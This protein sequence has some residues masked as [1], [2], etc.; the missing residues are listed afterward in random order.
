MKKNL[1]KCR[2]ED[3]E[4]IFI[5]ILVNEIH[6]CITRHMLSH[7]CFVLLCFDDYLWK[8]TSKANLL[9]SWCL[10]SFYNITRQMMLNFFGAL[11]SQKTGLVM[12]HPIVSCSIK[13]LITKD[14][15]IFRYSDIRPIST[16]PHNSLVF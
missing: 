1:L 9:I 15:G 2:L 6:I 5:F 16:L 13:W 3:I 12:K 10:V 11:C 7:S 8:V 14:C 4:W